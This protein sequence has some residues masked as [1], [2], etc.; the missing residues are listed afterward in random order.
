[1]SALRLQLNVILSAWLFYHGI[2][3]ALVTA[4]GVDMK[5]NFTKKK[6]TIGSKVQ[7]NWM[8]H[9]VQG[10]VSQIFHKPVSKIY[11]GTEFKRNGSPKK[12]AYLVIS[13]AGS[14]VLKS[15]TELTL[16]KKL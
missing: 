1:M 6:I 8:G 10:V 12:P 2:Y 13:K 14:R 11:R 15:H 5:A 16:R 4:G 3:F 7:W 9:H